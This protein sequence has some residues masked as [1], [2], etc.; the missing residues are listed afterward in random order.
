M[1]GNRLPYRDIPVELALELELELE[2][3]AAD[4][5][6]STSFL[7]GHAGLTGART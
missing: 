3:L 6:V 1:L 4:I 2:E 7:F 5:W